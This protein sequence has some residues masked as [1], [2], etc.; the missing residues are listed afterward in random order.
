MSAVQDGT[1]AQKS[2]HMFLLQCHVPLSLL[3]LF[4]SLLYRSPLSCSFKSGRIQTRR[5]QQTTNQNNI[6][7]RHP[8][9]SSTLITTVLLEACSNDN[10]TKAE[11]NTAL[12]QHSK[13]SMNKV[14]HK[15]DEGVLSYSELEPKKS[16]LNFSGVVVQGVF[17]VLLYSVYY[18]LVDEMVARIVT[19]SVKVLR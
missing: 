17:V 2:C 15:E 4:I 5:Q 14:G 12:P 19:V 1:G 10:Q 13:I 9:L 8:L 18:V 6:I 7:S 11:L 16:N 3:S